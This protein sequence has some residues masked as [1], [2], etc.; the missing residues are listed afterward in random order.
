MP[1]YPLWVRGL[2]LECLQEGD[3]IEEV[4]PF[5]GTWIEIPS[6]LAMR[7]GGFVV[8]FVGT[9]IEIGKWK[10]KSL[11]QCRRTLCGYVD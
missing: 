3:P 4:V 2:K 8:P 9:W 5:V 1:S 6:R 10:R 7:S 11:S